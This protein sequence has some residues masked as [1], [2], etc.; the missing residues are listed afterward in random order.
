M[1]EIPGS[2]VPGLGSR[3]GQGEGHKQQ[4]TW[5]LGPTP[6]SAERHRARPPLAVV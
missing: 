3:G 4:G 2:C 6:H 1:Q 5:P